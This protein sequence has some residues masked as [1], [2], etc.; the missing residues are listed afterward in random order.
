MKRSNEAVSG[1]AASD[2]MWLDRI[3]RTRADTSSVACCHQPERSAIVSS[4][5][6][7]LITISQYEATL[8]T[9]S[10]DSTRRRALPSFGHL[11]VPLHRAKRRPATLR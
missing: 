2:V 10:P 1:R 5:F 4:P 6:C 7:V 3:G 8:T 11:E 9:F